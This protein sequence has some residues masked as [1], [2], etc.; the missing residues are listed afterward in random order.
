MSHPLHRWN[1]S[2]AWRPVSSAPRTIGAE[3]ALAFNE[4][5]FFV[6]EDAF[7][8]QELVAVVAEIDPWEA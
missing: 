4:R 7:T 3:Q 6:F 8:A 2:F 5:G 1:E